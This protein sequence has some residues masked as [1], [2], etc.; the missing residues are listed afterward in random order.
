M[1]VHFPGGEEFYGSLQFSEVFAF[2]QIGEAPG[3]CIS[4]FIDFYLPPAQNNPDATHD[5]LA[6]LSVLVQN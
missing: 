5:G 3:R 1:A 2:S 4:A 6:S